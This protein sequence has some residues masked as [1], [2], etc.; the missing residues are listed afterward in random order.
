MARI[1]LG[2]DFYLFQAEPGE[3]QDTLIISSHGGIRRRNNADYTVPW[4]TLHYYVNHGVSLT[5]P[6]VLRMMYAPDPVESVGAGEDTY[7]YDLSKFQGQKHQDSISKKI[8]R[9]VQG[10][11]TPRWETYETIEEV[12]QVI[13]RHNTM[14]AAAGDA[15]PADTQPYRAADVLTIRNRFRGGSTHL[16]DALTA[17]G[18]RHQYADVHCVFCRSFM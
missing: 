13:Q 6:G 3:F 12:F 5:D 9:K 1:E 17:V 10:D 18:A 15:A 11:P 14:L 16:S 8:S 4:G 2:E 7:D